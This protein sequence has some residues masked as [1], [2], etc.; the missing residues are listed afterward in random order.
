VEPL[1]LLRP[2][3]EAA[4]D[5]AQLRR[6]KGR[7]CRLVRQ[8]H[9][10]AAAA[11]GDAELLGWVDRW[12]EEAR[13][14]GFRTEADIVRYFYAMVYVIKDP[15]ARRGLQEGIVAARGQGVPTADVTRQLVERVTFSHGGGR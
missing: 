7:A 6:F 15:Q 5:K 12:Y 11:I 10:A 14:F 3:H 4:F 13:A 8:E 1:F 2:E 9:R